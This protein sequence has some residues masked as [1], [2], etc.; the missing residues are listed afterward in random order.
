MPV[1]QNL[2]QVC[3][4]GVVEEQSQPCPYIELFLNYHIYLLPGL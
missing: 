3:V 2:A 1:L 4:M